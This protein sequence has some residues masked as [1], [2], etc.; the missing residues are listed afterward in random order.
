MRS[1]GHTESVGQ[2]PVPS[3]NIIVW[4]ETR[5]GQAGWEP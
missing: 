1:C 4:P 2:G 3:T 5:G